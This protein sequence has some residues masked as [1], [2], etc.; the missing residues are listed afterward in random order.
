MP[1]LDDP[2]G[3]SDG[4][5]QLFD[6]LRIQQPDPSQPS[7]ADA[8][9]ANTKALGDI[10]HSQLF[11][12]DPATSDTAWRSFLAPAPGTTYAA[13][14]WLPVARDDATGDYRLALPTGLR[15]FAKG[16]YD[17]VRGP[18]TGT[19]TPEATMALAAPALARVLERPSGDV[20][21]AF[22][23]SQRGIREAEVAAKAKTAE[24]EPPNL[25]GQVIARTEGAPEAAAPAETATP[26]APAAPAT[27]LE[28]A[29]AK[30]EAEAAAPQPLGDT[31]MLQQ[32][33]SDGLREQDRVSTRIPTAAPPKAG[34]LPPDPHRT[35]E[36]NIGIQA[37]RDS[38]PAFDKNAMMLRDGDFPD[39]PVKGMRNP[40]NIADASVGA[41][42]NNLVW[43]HDQM[44][45]HF[46]QD[47]VDRAANWYDG[48]HQIAINLAAKTG[49]EP[50]QIA[51]VMAALSPQKDWYQNADL[52]D[53]L[54]DIV[55]NGK[56]QAWT[57][58]MT[59]WA[60]KYA[61][62]KAADI[63]KDRAKGKDDTADGKQTGLDTFNE[64]VA[65][66]QGG[67]HPLQG[68]P[69][70]Q[71]N[72]PDVAKQRLYDRSVFVRAMDEAHH[73]RAYPI[74]TPEG[75][76]GDLAT[77][78][79]GSTSNIGWGSFKEIGKAISALD[80]P[81]LAHIS[82]LMGGNHKVRSFYNNI[83]SPNSQ[84]DDTTIDT[85]AINATHLRP[86]GGSHSVVKFGLGMGGSSSNATGAQGG[87]GL[88]HE[89]YRQATQLLNARPGAQ[90][91]L[92]RQLQSIAWEA[93]RGL[94]TPEQ[95][96]DKALVADVDAI[97]NQA[98]NR[99]ITVDEARNQILTRVKGIEPPSWYKPPP[100]APETPDEEPT[101]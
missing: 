24:A 72:D 22:S 33:V 45:Q 60:T 94:F 62:E 76:F 88:E 37:A 46:G 28:A 19:M 89:A 58:E 5:N 96:R 101:P 35:A 4:R 81:D 32:I 9:S 51:A 71:I 16:V 85:H 11:S 99:Q 15:D 82:R 93:V 41:M 26:A 42:A 84:R 80:N 68:L 44:V 91:L 98:R 36:L 52:G 38:D 53:R 79:D 87:Y 34:V 50:R 63:A 59:D 61:G 64:A 1:T 43:L 7:V 6:P 86:M 23:G 21:S 30:T 17:A 54:I 57:P 77:N 13:S 2:Y 66:M 40:G 39:L 18:E 48:A 83:I 73:S 90:P 75:T 55:Q 31:P 74:V 29:V 49:Y 65:R 78:D 8:W 10:I 67:D 27:P 95:K 12:S 56:N 25:L 47:T 92:P 69:L 70:W 20:L 3:L 97:W 100:P 14:P